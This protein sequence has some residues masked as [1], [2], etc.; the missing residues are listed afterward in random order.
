M[1]L[2]IMLC[3]LS[4]LLRGKTA[5]PAEPTPTDVTE[6]PLICPTAKTIQ[7]AEEVI[8]STDGGHTRNKNIYLIRQSGDKYPKEFM[9]YLDLIDNRKLEELLERIK[10]LCH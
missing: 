4:V 9:W 8:A 10:R 3:L 1:W 7:L 6:E 2:L 5:L